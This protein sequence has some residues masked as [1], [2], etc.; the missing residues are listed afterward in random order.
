MKITSNEQ[1]VCPVCGNNEFGSVND[2]G[3]ESAKPFE[4]LSSDDADDAGFYK[5]WKCHNCGCTGR[6]YY[7]FT[8]HYDVYETD[9]ETRID[10]EERHNFAYLERDRLLELLKR[11][12][13]A[14][15]NTTGEDESY[16]TLYDLADEI[17]ITEDEYNRVMKN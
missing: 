6:E 16:E 1:G 14:I 17:G 10:T 11:A 8:D 7:E 2:A 3:N 15:H 4:Y 9:G 13:Q 12:I 5:S